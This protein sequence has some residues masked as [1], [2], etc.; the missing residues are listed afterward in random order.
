MTFKA[1][2][3]YNSLTTLTSLLKPQAQH[4]CL[5]IAMKH[6]YN[7]DIAVKAICQTQSPVA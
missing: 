6:V 2:N 4:Y 1:S 5:E 7:Y 3:E